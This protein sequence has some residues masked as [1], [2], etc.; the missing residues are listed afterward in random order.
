MAKVSEKSGQLAERLAKILVKL[1]SG[2]KLDI[3]TLADDLNVSERTIFRDIGRLESANLVLLRD[4]QQRY[5]L[6]SKSMGIFKQKDIK[7][8]AQMSG[9]HS[10]YPNLA[11]PFLTKLLNHGQL[12]YTAKGYTHEDSSKFENLLDIFSEAIE[13]KRQVGFLYNGESRV[14][15]PYRLIH[16]HGSWYLAAVRKGQLRTYRVSRITRSYEQYQLENFSHNRDVLKQLEDENSIWFGQEKIEVKLKVHADVISHFKQRKL[17]PE[18]DDNPIEREDGSWDVSCKIS[19]AMQLLPL[20]RYWIPH[21]EI[22]SP[23]YLQDDLEEG[24]KGYLGR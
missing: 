18:Q 17:L 6:D 14:V 10:L 9:V 24:L 13:K 20:V 11:T 15:D 21:V 16:H 19:H 4:D 7:V 23:D 12:T 8:F 5:Y 2:M 22:I 3:K 1:N